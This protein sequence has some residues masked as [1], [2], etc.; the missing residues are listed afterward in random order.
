[1]SDVILEDVGATTRDDKAICLLPEA[2]VELPTL[3]AAS[4]RHHFGI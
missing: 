4:Q 3:P 1:M 2:S